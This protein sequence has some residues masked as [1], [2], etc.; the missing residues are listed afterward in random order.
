MINV[1]GT[2]ASAGRTGNLPGKA[3]HLASAT[4][5]TEPVHRL[6]GMLHKY[7][8]A[9]TIVKSKPTPEASVFS[10]LYLAITAELA[11]KRDGGNR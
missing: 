6:T 2:L 5:V 8:H 3:T 7:Q 1:V 10:W 11:A 9:L 4:A